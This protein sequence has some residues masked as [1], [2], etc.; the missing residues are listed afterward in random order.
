MNDK[1]EDF[2]KDEIISVRL[3]RSKYEV[4]RKIIEREESWNWFQ[5]WIINNWIFIFG[6]G[7]LSL[8]LL[9]DQIHNFFVGKP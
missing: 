1:E 3:P 2:V 7:V 6:S 8:I 9:Y 5:R 4:L